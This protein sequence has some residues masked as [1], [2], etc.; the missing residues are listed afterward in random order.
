MTNKNRIEFQRHPI[1]HMRA[2]ANSRTNN[3]RRGVF[4]SCPWSKK[5]MEI[6]NAVRDSD[7]LCA[8]VSSAL[9]YAQ[10]QPG[11]GPKLGHPF[12]QRN[13][14]YTAPSF[15]LPCTPREISMCSTLSQREFNFRICEQTNR[16]NGFFPFAYIGGSPF[17]III[18]NNQP[19]EN[20]G[21]DTL[22]S[23]RHSV[24]FALFRMEHW[25]YR[26]KLVVAATTNANEVKIDEFDFAFNNW[27]SFAPSRTMPESSIV[28]AAFFAVIVI[29]CVE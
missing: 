6:W 11:S 27:M 14:L 19:T 9:E 12:Y 3:I 17:F 16:I 5:G 29:N 7:L 15:T 8:A 18:N 4:V 26:T 25:N 21:C 28:F 1:I 20:H 2:N 22:W 13:V 10:Y 24:E 23:H